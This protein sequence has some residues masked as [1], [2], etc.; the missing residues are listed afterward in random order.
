MKKIITLT[1]MLIIAG[2][3]Y[4]YVTPREEK[5]DTSSI[6]YRV[7]EKENLIVE[8]QVIEEIPEEEFTTYISEIEEDVET[9]TTKE[10]LTQ[11]DQNTLKNTFITLTDFIFYGGEIKGYTF[12]ELTT[13]A[14]EKVINLYEKIDSKIESKFPGYKETIKET[15][16]KTYNNIKEK[17]IDIKEELVTAYKNEI[18]EDRYNSQVETFN[19]NK[20]TMKESWE[21]VIDTIKE[22]S[23]KAYESAKD[24]LDTWYQGWKEENS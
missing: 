3:I 10:T 14:K 11:E 12:N 23:V 15:S 22:E 1:I 2:V 5:T 8:E 9:L 21:P 16:T 18:G 20:E 19:E 17:V 7:T 4:Y 6:E 24:K 13:S